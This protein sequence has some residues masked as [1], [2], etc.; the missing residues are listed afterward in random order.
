MYRGPSLAHVFDFERDSH[1]LCRDLAEEGGGQMTENIRRFTPVGKRPF[2]EGYV[3][4]DLLASIMQKIVVVYPSPAGW[5]YESGTETNLDYAVYVE[6]GTGL[7]G[8]KRAKYE[9]TPKNPNGWLRFHD[10][11]GNVIFAK[12]VMH[13]G[14]PGAHMFTRGAELT[15]AGFKAWADNNVD[16]WAIGVEAE[17]MVRAREKVLVS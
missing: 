4:G 3:P 17:I 15:E 7:W 14:S 2:E 12:R 5:V 10:K 8:P 13:P 1:E 9:I 16:R 11:H 6:H